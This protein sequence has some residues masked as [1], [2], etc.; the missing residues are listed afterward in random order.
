LLYV[1]SFTLFLLLA[2]TSID[3]LF[4]VLALHEGLR[5]SMFSWSNNFDVKEDDLGLVGV[6]PGGLS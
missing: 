5:M 1:L 4:A 6:R 2:L 3:V